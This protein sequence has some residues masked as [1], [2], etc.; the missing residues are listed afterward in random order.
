ME[1]QGVMGIP[2]EEFVRGH[3]ET[4]VIVDCECYDAAACATYGHRY[5]TRATSRFRPSPTASDCKGP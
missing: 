3:S 2:I 5:W 4:A 1:Y